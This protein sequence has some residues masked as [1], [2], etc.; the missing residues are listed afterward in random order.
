MNYETPAEGILKTG[1]F[2]DSRLYKVVCS[3]GQDNHEH[4]IWIE[5]DSNDVSVNIYATV[6]TNFWSKT[7]WQHIWQLLSKGYTDLETSVIMTQQQSFNYA[8]T[9]LSAVD[10]VKKFKEEEDGKRQANN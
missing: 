1:D 3:C 5:A 10:D 2:G 7:R 4:N 8:H 6:K 9:L